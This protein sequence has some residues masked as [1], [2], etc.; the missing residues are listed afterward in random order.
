MTKL[1]NQNSAPN[2]NGVAYK[3]KPT[4]HA[5]I[6]LSGDSSSTP[7]NVTG[8][9]DPLG[10]LVHQATDYA[11]DEV[12]LWASNHSNSSNHFLTIEIGGDG[13]F[14]DPNQTFKIQLLKESGLTQIYPGLPHNG[15]TTIYARADTDDVINIYGYV[16]RHYRLDLTDRSLGYDGG[17]SGQ[18]I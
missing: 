18:N 6:N 13:T 12:F 3:F 8:T 2:I 5:R 15:N 16:D 7:I 4:R 14:S 1:Q 11:H 17:D 10:T 9:L